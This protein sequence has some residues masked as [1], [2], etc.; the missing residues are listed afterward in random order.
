M[1]M[2]G[3]LFATAAM[4]RTAIHPFAKIASGTTIGHFCVI[5]S[6]VAIG[7]GCRLGHHV[8]VRA[9][10][11]IGEGV[12]IGD[13][14][15]LGAAPMRASNSALRAGGPL[16]SLKVGAHCLIGAGVVLYQGCTLD[17]HVMVADLAT[18]REEVTVGMHTIIGR[19]V[20]V[21]NACTIGARCKLETNAYITAYSTLEDHVFVAPGVLTSN[22]NFAGRTRERY[23]HYKG[24][25]ARRGARIGVGAVILPGKEIGEDALIAGGS[26]VTRDVPSRQV[27]ARNPARFFRNVPEA[28]LLE[29][30]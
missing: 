14:A 13:H 6:D 7:R 11:R 24:V 2:A 26:V 29:N 9:G 1:R 12:R 27:W 15:T 21:E 28:Q 20:A 22:D 19:G 17:E 18:V 10:T 16:A 5:E 30:Q 23:K 8:V 3:F 25:I 4:S